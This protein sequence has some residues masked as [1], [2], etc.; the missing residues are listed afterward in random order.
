[1]LCLKHYQT[2]MVL[3][4]RQF[5]LHLKKNPSFLLLIKELCL[6]KK[7]KQEAMLKVISA[8]MLPVLISEGAGLS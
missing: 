5:Y 7:E 8:F 3:G 4:L 2:T 1:M 6:L